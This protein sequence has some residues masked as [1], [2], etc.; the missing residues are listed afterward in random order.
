MRKRVGIP[1]GP[2]VILGTLCRRYKLDRQYQRETDTDAGSASAR[3][4][5]Q[6]LASNSIKS[7]GL[8]NQTLARDR[9]QRHE[10]ERERER[11]LEQERDRLENHV[12]PETGTGEGEWRRDPKISR[13]NTAGIFW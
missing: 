11:K 9:V 7:R 1:F 10:G 4:Q 3:R 13:E 8:V 6:D 2:L 12:C 5:Y